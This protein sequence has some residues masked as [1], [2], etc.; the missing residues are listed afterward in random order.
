[1][2]LAARNV[3]I[4]SPT[5]K[6]IGFA[7]SS[8]ASTGRPT[9]V[10]SFGIAHRDEWRQVKGGAIVPAF[11]DHLGTDPGGVSKRHCKRW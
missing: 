1:M 7:R 11:G 8:I 4:G 6:R 3:E 5:S 2:D 10:Q 9:P